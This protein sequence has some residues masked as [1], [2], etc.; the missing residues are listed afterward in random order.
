M[1][2][3][4]EHYYEEFAIHLLADVCLDYLGG[5]VG[6][7]GWAFFPQLLWWVRADGVWP[8][9]ARGA[10]AGLPANL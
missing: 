8:G 6:T 9:G 5:S 10:G 2:L 1:A 7:S 3:Q 4:L